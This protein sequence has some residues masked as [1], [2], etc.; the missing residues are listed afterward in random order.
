MRWCTI[1]LNNHQL[2]R[3]VIFNSLPIWEEEVSVDLEGVEYVIH[4]LIIVI[5]NKGLYRIKILRGWLRWWS[6]VIS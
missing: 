4:G 3:V 1:L 6:L 5:H 2:A